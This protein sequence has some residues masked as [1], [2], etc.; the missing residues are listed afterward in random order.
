MTKAIRELVGPGVC[1]GDYAE[2]AYHAN[3]ELIQKSWNIEAWTRNESKSVTTAFLTDEESAQCLPLD[4][5]FWETISL[6]N[7]CLPRI[8]VFG[9][10]PNKLIGVVS[11]GY[12]RFLSW[13]ES[14]LWASILAS[15]RFR[16][17]IW[18]M[19]F[20]SFVP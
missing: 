20:L 9:M 7:L 10:L 5:N 6:N 12:C 4:L 16:A 8:H 2:D 19:I 15:T 18:A 1:Q 14:E 17:A 13:E 11:E 3:G